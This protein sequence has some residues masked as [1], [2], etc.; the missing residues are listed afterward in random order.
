MFKFNIKPTELKNI[1]TA[2]YP[3][4]ER[5]SNGEINA[6]ESESDSIVPDQQGLFKIDLYQIMLLFQQ[7]KAF[8]VM[9][10]TL[11]NGQLQ[12]VKARL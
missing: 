12:I 7:I 11:N 3:S 10:D 9:W 4:G 6:N 2:Y 5:N 1:T 8:Q